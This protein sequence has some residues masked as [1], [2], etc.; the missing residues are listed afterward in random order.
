MKNWKLSALLNSPSGRLVVVGVL[1]LC[2]ELL[3]MELLHGLFGEY[4]HLTD[5]IWNLIDSITLTAVIAPL[6][7]FLVFRKILEDEERFRQINN[8]AL[9]AIVIIDEQGRITDWNR[10]AHN[11]F[12]YSQEEAVGQMMHQ[13]IAPP[14][15][16]ADAAHGFARFEKS[17]EGM[18][19]DKTTEI[20]ALR[21][22]GS[23][24]PIEL[25]LS[26]VKLKNRWHAIGVMRDNTERKQAGQERL[27]ADIRIKDALTNTIGA[28]AATLEQRDP[29]TAGHQRRVSDLA[30]AIGTEMGLAPD[31]ME[32]IH[33]GG[34]IHDIGKISVPAEILGKPGRLN[35]IEFALIREHAEAGYQ[36]VRDI[37]FSWPV[38]K[39][40]HQHHERLDGTGYPQGLSGEQIIPEA[41]IL[42]VADVVEAMSSNRPYRP[43]LGLDAALE[44]ITRGRGAQFDPVVVDACLRVIREK[45]FV[46]SK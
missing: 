6:L 44:E 25:S 35:D 31:V 13:L 33:F 40:V 42:A 11:M 39:M 30:V 24:F 10:A 1:V 2:V 43:G 8:A 23:E 19:I 16:H 17:G 36:I 14:R 46:F 26:A 15:Y 37:A 5:T 18:L 21:K 34:L 12:Q 22:D 29:Y 27:K 4:V 7:Y 3:I 9:N 20:S 32:G 45:G 28:I 38:A 41:R